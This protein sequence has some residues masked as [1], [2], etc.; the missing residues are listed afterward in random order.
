MKPVSYLT[1][2]LTG[3]AILVPL[4]STD[5]LA[6]DIKIRPAVKV[7]PKVTAKPKVKIAP[8]VVVRPK[9]KLAPK[10]A[11]K[12]RIKIA[13]KVAAV[14]GVK[15]VPDPATR[16]I[17]PRVKPKVTI[18]RV[19]V[20]K[21]RNRPGN[22]EPS[23]DA[24]TGVPIGAPDFARDGKFEFGAREAANAAEAARNLVGMNDI[25]AGATAEFT[26]DMPDLGGDETPGNQ[27][28]LGGL[29]GRNG[30]GFGFGDDLGSG[31]SLP[32]GLND[33]HSGKTPNNPFA[34]TPESIAQGMGGIAGQ[35]SVRLPLRKE[36]NHSNDIPSYS[37]NGQVST[38]DSFKRRPDGTTTLVHEEHDV[39]ADTHTTRHIERDRD[40]NIT[41]DSGTQPIENE[42][43]GT[44]ATELRNPNHAGGNPDC[45]GIDCVVGTSAPKGLITKKTSNNQVLT[46]APDQ[47]NP[48]STSGSPV[49]SQEQ[50]LSRYDTERTGGSTPT[51]IDSTGACQDC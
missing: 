19:P 23:S 30:S 44:S 26:L 20:P 27:E 29:S 6:V 35:R 49:L 21:P 28:R 40:G 22:P 36:V 34:V 47:A 11:V 14:P 25:R 48:N 3:A 50:L 17:A 46:A 8:K 51:P 10:V 39:L 1:A 41:E 9:V 16:P 13:P 43:A 37:S 7:H 38:F 33:T 18:A 15:A 12:P 45:W 2:L 24:T 31:T 4:W 5:A 32:G 42:S